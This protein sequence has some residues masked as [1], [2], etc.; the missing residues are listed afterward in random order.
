VSGIL[1]QQG[2]SAQSTRGAW[3]ARDRFAPWTDPQ[4]QPLV[5]YDAVGKRFGDFTALN[6]VSLD[7]YAG[8]FFALLG[9]SGCG[10]TTLLRILAGLESADAGRILLA[11]HDLSVVPAHRRPVNMMFQNY[12]LF[13]HLSVEGNIAFGLK[14]DR[15][16]K[17]EIETRVREML[18]LVKL[19][20]F[21]RRRPQ[22]LSGGQRQRVALARSLA[23]RPRVL[24]L[25]E[26]LAALD[27]KLRQQT[28][29]ELKELQAK[30]GLT[31]VIVTHDQEEA[32]TV[33]SRIGVMREGSLVQVGTPAEVYEQPNSRWVADFIGE[34]NLIEGE[35]LSGEGRETIIASAPGVR[36]RVAQASPAPNGAR[37]WLALR[38]EKVRI[39]PVE[40]P[41]LRENCMAGKV[42]ELG[43]LGGLSTYKVRLESGN[44]ML[45][46]LA[47]SVRHIERPIA[48]DDPVWL[49]WAP[50]AAIILT[51]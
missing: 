11:G 5:R 51:K 50:D 32:M 42:A 6:Q 47:N 16:P 2:S 18:A 34:V 29:F 9:P 3:G 20:G 46:T 39:A 26:P 12:A 48:V 10:K 41:S 31:F 27:R 15:L 14:Q 4:A 38:P 36:L 21:G 28:Q 1:D 22:Q 43:Y 37:V 35:V 30:L 40:P 13:P 19:E 24:L 33:A 23:K 44:R 7:I 49:S 8:E 45:A 17:A 25:D